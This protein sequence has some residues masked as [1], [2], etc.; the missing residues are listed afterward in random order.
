MAKK[1]DGLT[2]FVQAKTKKEKQAGATSTKTG[3]GALGKSAVH[4]G[5]ENPEFKKVTLTGSEG[6]RLKRGRVAENPS[7]FHPTP[8]AQSAAPRKVAAPKA[9]P[10]PKQVSSVRKSI[11]APTAPSEDL[12]AADAMKLML[13]CNQLLIEFQDV[14]RAFQKAAAGRREG[15][16]YEA[17]RDL[18]HA[19]VLVYRCVSVM[20]EGYGLENLKKN[21]E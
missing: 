1:S 18:N 17:W 6:P 3:V 10:V 19:Q 21:Q 13:S 12:S 5:S 14:A 11:A 16:A 7:V 4:P 9:N 20:R 15:P 2:A 8:P